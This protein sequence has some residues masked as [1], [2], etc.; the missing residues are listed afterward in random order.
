MTFDEIFLISIASRLQATT[1]KTSW[2][3]TQTEPAPDA[4]HSSAN[5]HAVVNGHAH[6][7]V[8]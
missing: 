7:Q 3:E 5:S 4:S 8:K 1:V 2:Q 6:A